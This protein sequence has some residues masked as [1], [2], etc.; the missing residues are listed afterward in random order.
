MEFACTS[1]AYSREER[2][3]ESIWSAASKRLTH[4]K[5]RM[6]DDP[7][8]P[9]IR[10][11]TIN[12][13]I[14]TEDEEIKKAELESFRL[15]RKDQTGELTEKRDLT[16][17]TMDEIAAKIVASNDE[18]EQLR[19]AMDHQ[20]YYYKRVKL[21]TSIRSEKD[22]MST[23]MLEDL[24]E[25]QTQEIMAALN[26][27]SPANYARMPKMFSVKEAAKNLKVSLGADVCPNSFDVIPRRRHSPNR[28]RNRFPCRYE[29]VNPCPWVGGTAHA[30]NHHERNK[31]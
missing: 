8:S 2:R 16:S 19:L 20:S 3:L 11:W 10:E 4:H 23:H 5:K 28:E 30:R 9:L 25:D 18:E 13:R 26:N 12:L 24:G 29:G 22:K 14:Y 17:E 7:D 21:D 6:A 31:H 27:P 15:Q 1:S